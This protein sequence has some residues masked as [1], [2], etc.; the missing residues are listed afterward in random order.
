MKASRAGRASDLF[1]PSLQALLSPHEPQRGY[2]NGLD[3]FR[4][5][6]VSCDGHTG[7]W[8]LV[9]TCTPQLSVSSSSGGQARGAPL[10]FQ[11]RPNLSKLQGSINWFAHQ[12]VSYPGAS[13]SSRKPLGS[14][15]TNPEILRLRSAFR[16][17]CS[18]SPSS[19]AIGAKGVT[20]RREWPG[21]PLIVGKVREVLMVTVLEQEELGALCVDQITSCVSSM[22]CRYSVLSRSAGRAGAIEIPLTS[23]FTRMRTPSINRAWL[24]EI[25][26]P[27]RPAIIRGVAVGPP[28]LG[29][30]GSTVHV[31]DA[32]FGLGC[33]WRENASGGRGHHLR[34]CY[35]TLIRAPL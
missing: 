7:E 28:I 32:V 35:Q 26:I 16:C 11:G 14:G 10:V 27:V 3:V 20:A 4:L 9:R 1:L 13:Q 19:P 34:G 21:Q 29:G 18:R 31:A 25:K 6:E 30:R 12:L 23:S 15:R 22:L 8:K 33:R 24:G 5:T 17:S 2:A